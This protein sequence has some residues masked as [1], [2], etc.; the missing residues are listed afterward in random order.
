MF[1]KWFSKCKYL[2]ADS[3]PLRVVWERPFVARDTTTV[4][5]GVLCW[6]WV[7]MIDVEILVVY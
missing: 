4:I 2:M 1:T 3:Y 7:E 5:N 6:Q